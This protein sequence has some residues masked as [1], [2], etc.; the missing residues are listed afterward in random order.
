MSQGGDQFRPYEPHRTPVMIRLSVGAEPVSAL[1]Y[2]PAPLALHPPFMITSD[3][4]MQ[5]SPAPRVRA[6]RGRSAFC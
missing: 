3:E 5:E 6:M 2:W 1:A 4:F